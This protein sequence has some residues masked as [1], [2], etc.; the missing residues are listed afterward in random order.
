MAL[1]ERNSTA[2]LKRAVSYKLRHGRPF[3][4]GELAHGTRGVVT[5]YRSLFGLKDDEQAREVVRLL[6]MKKRRANELPCPCGRRLER[7][8]LNDALR[9]FR[10]LAHRKWGQEHTNQLSRAFPILPANESRQQL[11]RAIPEQST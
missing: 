4:F 5:D 8:G 11:T 10:P 9:E 1:S 7:C 3:P 6:G 2:S